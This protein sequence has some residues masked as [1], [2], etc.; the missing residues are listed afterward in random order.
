M[1]AQENLGGGGG[2]TTT[3][4]SVPSNSN[5]SNAAAQLPGTQNRSTWA[6][7]TANYSTGN[8][9]DTSGH[10]LDATAYAPAAHD[11]TTSS[12]P[13]AARYS[14]TTSTDTAA[15]KTTTA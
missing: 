5:R 14:H 13:P 3:P 4:H 10:T 1:Y 11:T 2:P 12:G 15:T 9:A 8:A 7:T 6:P